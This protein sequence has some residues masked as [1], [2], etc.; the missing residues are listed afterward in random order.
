M[1]IRLWIPTACLCVLLLPALCSAQEADK[2]AKHHTGSL[3]AGLS[4][5]RGN[6][7]TTNFNVSGNMTYDPKTKNIMKFE[8]LYLKTRSDDEDTADRLSLGFRDEY[9]ISKR[10]FVYGAMGYLRDPFMDIRYL[11]NP[12]GGLGFKLIATERTELRMSGGGGSVWEKNSGVDVRT[13]G[14]VNAGENF[15]L[16]LSKNASFTQG[17]SALWKTE[18]FSDALYHFN[19]ALVTSITS[20]TEVKVEFLDDYKNVTPTPDIKKNDT[21]F[22][23]SFLYKI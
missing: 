8:G 19:V 12:Q 6:T 15:S 21:A 10:L 7:R 17:F 9:T 3:G 1:K 13:S 5:T 14:T 11:L 23:V 4:F 2:P 16:K 22:I 18:N 20:K